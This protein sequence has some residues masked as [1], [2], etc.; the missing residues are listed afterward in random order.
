MYAAGDGAKGAS[1][2]VKAIA[3]SK[4][5]CEAILNH[6]I[7]ELKVSDTTDE[8]VYTYR[9]TLAEVNEN[10]SDGRC[11]ACDYICENC[12]EVC[13]NRANVYV[14]VEGKH[15]IVHVDYMCNECGNCE[16][17]CPY[18]SA[19]YKDKLTLFASEADM[20][21]SENDGF[22]ITRG[23]KKVKVRIDGKVL[24]YNIGEENSDLYYRYK[25][26]IDAIYND[27]EYLLL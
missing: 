16:T 25:E 17:F 3:D 14:K 20:E 13:P 27:Y 8:A 24:D 26:V 2:I 6:K 10:G 7:G 22:V 5:V 1:V 18:A 19:P 21:D 15:Q 23:N 9:G 12:T 11:L 4:K